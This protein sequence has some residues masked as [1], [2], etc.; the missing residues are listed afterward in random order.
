M[1][2]VDF[3]RLD[4]RPG[5]RLLDIGCGTGRHTGEAL[6]HPWIHAVGADRDHADLVRARNRLRFHEHTG[7]CAGGCWS[8]TAADV[9]ALPF[10]N[11]TFDRVICSEVL[12]HVGDDRRAA[13]ELTRVL[14]PGGMLVVSVPRW[15]PE[16]ICWLLS[17][18]YRA[19][20]GGHVRIY[21]HLRLVD[22]LSMAGLQHR[23]S[24]FAHALHSPYWWLKCL[25]GPSRQD[26]RAVNLYHRFLCWEM[27]RRPRWTRALDAMLNPLI[28]KSLVLYFRKP[29]TGIVVIPDA[30]PPAS[31]PAAALGRRPSPVPAGRPGRVPA[32]PRPDR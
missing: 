12:E 3:R 31:S 29:A 13:R 23:G 15:L 14:R 2:T 9:T 11:A 10:G 1:L 4:L 25:V 6:R 30:A 19:T 22:L 8:L 27:M 24:A 7:A 21:R 17:T 26:C 18:E 32:P 5:G 16:R 20:P 28:G